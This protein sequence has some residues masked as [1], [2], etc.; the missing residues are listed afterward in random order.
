VEVTDG[1][2]AYDDFLAAIRG[3]FGITDEHEMQLAFDCADPV[4]G[5]PQSRSTIHSIY[6]ASHPQPDSSFPNIAHQCLVG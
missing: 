2:G 4:T 6:E 5:N 1:E 3:I